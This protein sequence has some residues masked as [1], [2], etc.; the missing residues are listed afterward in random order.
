MQSETKSQIP[1]RQE[2]N[3]RDTSDSIKTKTRFWNKE[4]ILK[5]RESVTLNVLFSVLVPLITIF[6][7]EWIAR[8]SFAPNKQGNGFFQSLIN[9]LPSYLIA[10][11]LLFLIYIFICQLSGWHALAT[12]SVGLIGNIPA[13][14]TYYKL[15]MRGEPFLPWDLTQI[16]DLMGV[17]SSVKFSPQ[18][19]MIITFAIFVILTFLAAFVK[20]PRKE[21]SG[22]RDYKTNFIAAGLALVFGTAMVF[23]VFLNP[24][25]TEAV[26]IYEDM[27]MQ[28]RY[29]RK[30]GVLTGFLTNLQ[31][32]RIQTPDGYSKN[33]VKELAEITN[34]NAEGRQPLFNN[35]IAPGTTENQTPDIIFVMAESFWDMTR[36]PEIEYDQPLLSNLERLKNEGAFGYGYS[37][38]FGGGTCDVEFEALTG[39]SLEHLPSGSKPYQQYITQ[40]TFSLPWVLKSRGYDTL[41]IHGYGRKFWSRDTA[42]PR[43]GIDEFIAS[44]DFKNPEKRRGF[45][46]DNAMVNRIIEEYE[47]HEG[48]PTFIHAVTMQN[49]TT[50]NRD[51]YPADELVKVTKAP[52]TLSD[53]VVGELEDCATGI[54]EMDAALGKLTNY[55]KTSSRPTIVVFWGDHLNPMS[56]ALGIFEKTGFI[57][58]DD[59]NNPKLHEVP[60]LIWSNY[61]SDKI[62]LGVLS[63]YNIAPVMMDIYDLERPEMYEFLMQ[64]MPEVKGRTR[65]ITINPDNSFTTEPTEKQQQAFNNHGILQYDF[66]FG[67]R[68]LESYIQEK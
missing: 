12:A 42:Y 29:Y 25:A 59:T 4:S 9:H 20:V 13:V 51:K 48:S 15:T 28:D 49:H 18:L 61:K 22:K 10:Y 68:T 35:S 1:V 11:L 55:L 37:P 33:K 63:T 46:S 21:N 34:K 19:N 52:S 31:L 2:K 62:D 24:K 27:W 36:L 58:N 23:G 54:R 45:I 60:L 53:K 17:K 56:D 64:Q 16:N 57:E 40:D 43:L 38:S 47:N 32:L 6:T 8:G 7:M 67:N 39:F 26:G 50:Y 66:L 41:A 3:T 44:E 65:G 30:H 5:I 14:I